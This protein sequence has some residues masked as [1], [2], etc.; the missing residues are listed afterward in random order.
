MVRRMDRPIPVFLRPAYRRA[1]E[2]RA[3]DLRMTE[4]EAAAHLLSG[5]LEPL[6]GSDPSDSQARAERELMAL[7]EHLVSAEL[8]RGWNE[9][10]TA[11]V[12]RVLEAKHLDL[13]QAATAAGERNRVNRLIGSRVKAAAAADVKS[14]HGKPVIGQL[15]RSSGA[16]IRRYTLLV[17]K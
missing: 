12:F 8:A 9:H 7:V 4:S 11:A 14:E 1:L 15:P 3:K 13:Y 5:A 2:A 6:L 16:L 10:L 17:P